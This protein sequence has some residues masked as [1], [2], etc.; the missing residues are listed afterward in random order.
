MAI[1]ATN[2]SAGIVVARSEECVVS[3]FIG[4]GSLR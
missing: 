3:A 2:N 4:A 1:F